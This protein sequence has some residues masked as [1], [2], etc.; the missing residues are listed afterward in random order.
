MTMENKILV[1]PPF[2]DI[3]DA[4]SKF[5]NNLHPLVIEDFC[6]DQTFIF[7]TI[8]LNSSIEV[9]RK[10]VSINHTLESQEEFNIL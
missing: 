8:S 7:Y 1:N 6:D 3:I 4:S 10:C 5:L 2:F 9:R